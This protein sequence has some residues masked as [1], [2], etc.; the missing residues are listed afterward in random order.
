MVLKA[1]VAQVVRQFQVESNKPELLRAQVNALSRMVPLLYFILIV[2]AW[3]L[4]FQ[5][6]GKAP[7]WLTLYGFTSRFVR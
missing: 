1:I 2:N 7:D 4:S 3:V 6:L 5:F